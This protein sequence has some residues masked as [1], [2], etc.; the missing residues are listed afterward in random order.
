MF[1]LI[2]RSV[3]SAGNYRVTVFRRTTVSDDSPFDFQFT[4]A[5]LRFEFRESE[6]KF[7]FEAILIT[8]LFHILINAMSDDP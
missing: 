8:L 1:V 4:V 7:L 6:F 5:H 3:K 2:F